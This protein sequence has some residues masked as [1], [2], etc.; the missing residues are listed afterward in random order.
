[1]NYYVINVSEDGYVYFQEYTKQELL[2]YLN[3]GNADHINFSRP[4][5]DFMELVGDCED[6]EGFIIKG[7]VV[8]PK[9][10]NVVSVVMKYDID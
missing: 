10:E 2:D 5:R 8:L 1:M 3:S 4:P 6:R 7:E 9:Q